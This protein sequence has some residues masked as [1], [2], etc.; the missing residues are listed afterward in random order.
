MPSTPSTST[1]LIKQTSIGT[2][3]KTIMVSGNGRQK[4]YS[5]SWDSLSWMCGSFSAPPQSTKNWL[6]SE[7]ILQKPWLRLSTQR[8]PTKE[9]RESD[10]QKKNKERSY[11]KI[12]WEFDPFFFFSPPNQ[13]HF[14]EQF[15]REPFCYIIFWTNL[16]KITVLRHC[17]SKKL[18]KFR[19]MKNS[20]KSATISLCN[21]K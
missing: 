18:K 3:S 14:Q 4:W 20:L 9:E 1:W 13:R 8:Q 19:K 21:L 5:P 17:F 6:H 12:Q 15:Q 2:S 16:P 10:F 11:S 7:K